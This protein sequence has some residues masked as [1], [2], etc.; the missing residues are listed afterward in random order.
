MTR[1]EIRLWLV[2][3]L[4]LLVGLAPFT[5]PVSRLVFNPQAVA[6][7]GSDVTL[8]RSFPMDVMFHDWR[9]R[10]SYVET[11]RPLG[12]ETNNGHPCSDSLGPR[13]YGREEAVGRWNINNWAA[14]CLADPTGFVWSAE[15][16]WHVGVIK[17]GPVSLERT[18][19]RG[20]G[21]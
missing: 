10:I 13:Q 15:W 1:R 19:F 6:I 7:N 8:S 4:V 12:Q 17:F 21:A 9:P 3:I 20:Q 16:F 18:F 14:P 2:A 5:A 11:V